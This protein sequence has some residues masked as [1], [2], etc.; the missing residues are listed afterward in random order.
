MAVNRRRFFQLTGATALSVAGTQVLPVKGDEKASGP[1]RPAEKPLVAKRWAMAIDI[2]KCREE[3]DCKDCVAACDKAHNVPHF[4]NPKDEVK[5]IW[6]EP[7]EEALHDQSSAFQAE[8]LQ[9]THVLVFCNHCDQPPCTKVC[10]TQATWKRDDGVVMMDWHRCI[11]CRYCVAGCP[12]GSRSFNWRDPRPHIDEANPDF[13]TR[14]R[15]VVEKCNFC[16]ERLARGEGPACVTACKGQ[17]LIFGDLE[18]PESEIRKVLRD[19]PSVRRKVA[20]GTQP[21]VFYLL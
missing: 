7:F 16:E 9:H 18:D 20:L 10:P 12:Y 5:W 2:A 3:T 15:G 19:R 13:P 14:T 1:A 17:A 6:K 21:E 11:G 4:D 8:H